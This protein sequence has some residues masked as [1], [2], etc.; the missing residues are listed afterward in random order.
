MWKVADYQSISIHPTN[1]PTCCAFTKPGPPKPEVLLMLPWLF[2]IR[3]FL[4]GSG[5]Q[6]DKL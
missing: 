6:E 1:L 4:I 5:K 3:Q 2:V